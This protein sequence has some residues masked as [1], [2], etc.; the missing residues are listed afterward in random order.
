MKLFFMRFFDYESEA[1]LVFKVKREFNSPE[2]LYVKVAEIFKKY[3]ELYYYEEMEERKRMQLGPPID[4]A[5]VNLFSF[6]ESVL[7]EDFKKSN[8]YDETPP[9]AWIKHGFFKDLNELGLEV[10]EPDYEILVY[11]HF[12]P[13][14]SKPLWYLKG[15][16]ESP[17]S[18]HYWLK[19]V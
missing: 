12:S 16:E 6:Y 14:E 13:K 2:E 18:I 17:E 7:E 8:I 11:G 3:L 10:V 15:S 4:P 9:F 1:T 5:G 19:R